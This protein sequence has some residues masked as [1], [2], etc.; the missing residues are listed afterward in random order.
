MML[1][2]YTTSILLLLAAAPFSQGQD[3]A[4]VNTSKSQFAKLQ[5]V[6]LTDV[7]WTT[8]FWADRYEV[9]EKSMM[10]HMLD[11]YLNDS[12]SHGYANFEIAAG[13]KEGEHIGP[14]FHDGDFYKMLEAAIVIA[15]ENNDKAL[16]EKIDSIIAVIGMTQR[17]DGYIHTPVMI[18]ERLHPET[19]K[20]FSE[21]MD[22]ETY[23]M[24]HLQTAACVHYR[25][26]GK[27]TLMDIAIRATEFLYNYYKDHAHELAQN[28][29]CPS[30]Y[31]GVTEM[32]R[33][34]GDPR[35]L[36]LATG[37]IDIRDQVEDGHDHNQDRIPFRRQ[38]KAQGHAVRAN[39][40]YAG[41]ADVYAETGDQSLMA[42]LDAIW[43]DLVGNK[44]YITGGCGALYDGVSPNGT[45]YDQP[46]IQQ[47]HQAYGADYEL[48]NLTAHNES[49]ANI[50]NLLWNYRMLQVTA[51]AKYA[52][53]MERVMYNSL[54]AAV[55]L[56]GIRHFYT[57]P[58]AVADELSHDL[59]WSKD[60]EPYISYCN[61]CPPNTAR[62]VAEINNYMYSLSDD[63][64]YVNFYGANE[65]NTTLENGDVLQLDQQT[66][67]PWDGKVELKV[68][69][70]LK[71][72]MT[73]H[74]RIPAWCKDAGLTVNGQPVAAKPEAGT[75]FA[76]SRKWKKGD[77]IRLN[78]PMP[79]QLM[80]SNPMVEETR[81]LVAVQRGPVVYCVETADLPA[82]TNVF[83][84]A[85][86]AAK[87]LKPEPIEI[88]GAKMI[89]LKGEGVLLTGSSWKN[90]L[91]QPVNLDEKATRI[92]LSFVPYYAWDN[93]G[94]GEMS[95]WILLKR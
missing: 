18:S 14:P 87:E 61:C 67:Y 25:L 15:A 42:A 53:V 45:T 26:T 37:L 68:L 12:I 52:D 9:C 89:A 2:K 79:V 80:E 29:I 22:F 81:G 38:T 51:D 16:T 78:L 58:L 50:G 4:L 93:R 73:L 6:N 13:L 40:L 55:S 71:N 24:G 85:V 70:T 11:M 17:A 41:A 77:Q 54:L 83:N 1:K 94:K 3:K 32:Y 7:K 64:L 66:D 8:G 63:G 43:N 59:R 49:C 20:T 90:K 75:Y 65:L 30:H 34:L 69:N 31:M 56:D 84:V 21:R 57:N 91:Y 27:R 46:S 82:G 86:D 74:L 92:A 36:E 39:Y 23:N 72:E 47:V 88:D 76:V 33:T 19:K 5:A 62:T 10:P 28:A 95:V 35:Y 44:L 60:R 48:P